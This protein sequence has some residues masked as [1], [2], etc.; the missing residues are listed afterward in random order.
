MNRDTFIDDGLLSV[1]NI[2]E[3]IIPMLLNLAVLN[4]LKYIGIKYF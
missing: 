4:G 2:V 1:S 3:Y